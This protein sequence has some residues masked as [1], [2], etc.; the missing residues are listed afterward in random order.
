MQWGDR[1]RFSAVLPGYSTGNVVDQRWCTGTLVSQNLVLTAGHCFDENHQGSSS[2]WVT[3]FRVQGANVQY[4]T[5]AQLA[6][7]LR[8]VFNYQI[9]NTSSANPRAVVARNVKRLVEHRLGGLDFA[10][11]ELEMPTAD[12]VVVPGGKVA[13]A[14][15]LTTNVAAGQVI[16]IIQHP[17]GALKKIDVGN[18]DSIT[19]GRLSYKNLDTRG[20]SSGSG[21]RDANG[22]VR[23]VHVE[24][25]CEYGVGNG[26][27]P[28]ESILSVSP[29]IK[30]LAVPS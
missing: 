2:G 16:A 5:P 25:G 8:A 28:I 30:S 22:A 3:P 24:G 4:A 7:A 18:V 15:V 17:A 21:V 20:G 10:V 11:F 29:T 23:A 13:P 26:A 19:N 9:D 12:I 14:K 6:P 27:V 1:T